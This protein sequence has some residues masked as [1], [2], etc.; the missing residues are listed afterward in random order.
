MLS[1][2]QFLA[3]LYDIKCLLRFL[4]GK[5]VKSAKIF[6]ACMAI[7]CIALMSGR[8][9]H[10][11]KSNVISMKNAYKRIE[12]LESVSEIPWL[13]VGDDWIWEFYQIVFDLKIPKKIGNY[14]LL[15]DEVRNEV[16]DSEKEAI[17]Y[18]MNL[19]IENI[20]EEINATSENVFIYEKIA[21]GYNSEIYHLY[22]N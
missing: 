7:V 20:I 15:S 10:V 1:T 19:D 17:I 14:S 5:K 12:C 13:Y 8:G 11:Q 6:Y 4:E 2:L 9:Y 18:C 21:E 3:L 16:L 22:V